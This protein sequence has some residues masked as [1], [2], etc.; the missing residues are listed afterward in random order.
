MSQV[1]LAVQTGDA[2]VNLVTKLA[3]ETLPG[4]VGAGVTLVGAQRKHT[5]AAS[6]SLVEQA[7]QLQYTFDAGPC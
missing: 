3:I 7:D 4:T 2:V 5:R 1:L 6:N